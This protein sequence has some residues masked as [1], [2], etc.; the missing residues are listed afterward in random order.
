MSM[1]IKIKREALE[2]ALQA[3]KNT[4]PDEFVGLFREKDG[5]ITE[6][7]LAPLSTYAESAAYFP[8]YAVPTDPSIVGTFHSHPHYGI[9][10]PSQADKRLFSM[11]YKCHFI[12]S[13]PYSSDSTNVFNTNGEQITFEVIGDKEESDIVDL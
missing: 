13:L 4:Y 7:L 5:I 10:Q 2:S 3:A 8:I 12:A 11:F 9:A 6:L 1:E